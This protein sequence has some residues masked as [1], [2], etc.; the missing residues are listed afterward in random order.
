MSSN[1][2]PL[3]TDT[4]LALIHTP[5]FET[6]KDD[7]FTMEASHMALS[8][9]SF[10]RGFN[11]IYQ[12]APRLKPSD[13]TD[14][15]GYCI[16]WADLV[17]THHHYE[18]TDFFPNVDKAAG[19]TGLMAG[20]VHEHEAFSTGLT[21]F[22]TY[23]VDKG[24]DFDSDELISILDSF[25]DPLYDHLKSEPGQ[26]VALSKYNTKEHPID[27]L[28][29]ADAAGKKVVTIPFLFSTLPVFF[30]NQETHEFED[31]MWHGVFPP[32][33][34]VAKAVMNKAVPM[35]NSGR[36]WRFVSCDADGKAKRLA[37]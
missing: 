1:V 26:I 24:A 13:K 22:K 5:K 11:T 34:T 27:I 28:A 30:L 32:L 20:A 31:G 35:W 29:I 16:A 17:L 15:A 36:R 4:P 7:P 3:Y 21:R 10:I 12:Q 9:N 37:V 14:F 19:Q 33:G 25:K 23:L 2:P 8:H 18:E 6:G